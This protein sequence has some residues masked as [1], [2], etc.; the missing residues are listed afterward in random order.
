MSLAKTFFAPSGMSNLARTAL[1]FQSSL[2]KFGVEPVNMSQS[3]APQLHIS[4]A[5]RSCSGVTDGFLNGMHGSVLPDLHLDV[6][7]SP[8]SHLGI[9]PV[10]AQHLRCR[11]EKGCGDGHRHTVVVLGI[12][13]VGYFQRRAVSGLMIEQQGVCLQAPD[14]DL[15]QKGCNVLVLTLRWR[16][17]KATGCGRTRL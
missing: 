14:G 3:I 5:C 17:A 9:I 12:P 6:G 11:V 2:A 16:A 15:L 10:V 7:V 8:V 13:E 1:T 4:A